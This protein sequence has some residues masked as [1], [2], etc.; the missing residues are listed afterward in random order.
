MEPIIPRRIRSA[1]S[2]MQQVLHGITFMHDG[3]DL[4]A[5]NPKSGTHADTSAGFRKSAWL[6]MVSRSHRIRRVCL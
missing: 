2:G 5:Q 6:A 1:C 3:A 4:D